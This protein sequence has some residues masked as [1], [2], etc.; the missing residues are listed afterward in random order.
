MKDDWT[1]L[2]LE[3]AGILKV[4]KTN[5]SENEG[6]RAL[7]AEVALTDKFISTLA[8][9][10]TRYCSAQ[11]SIDNFKEIVAETVHELL[12]HQDISRHISLVLTVLEASNIKKEALEK[13]LMEA[14]YLGA[15]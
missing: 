11:K 6:T 12:P 4:R 1:L 5:E 3:R 9:N 13:R 8:W 7:F 10:L 15:K 14:G 2:E